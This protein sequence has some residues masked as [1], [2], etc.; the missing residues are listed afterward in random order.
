M[1][2]YIKYFVLFILLIFIGAV[3]INLYHDYRL[4]D[5]FQKGNTTEEQQKQDQNNKQEDEEQSVQINSEVSSEQ[6][7]VDQ[8]ETNTES[9]DSDSSDNVSNSVQNSS[10]KN[11]EAIEQS[12]NLD[13]YQVDSNSDTNQDEYI[14]IE[15]DSNLFRSREVPS[16]SN[17]SVVVQEESSVFS[18][19]RGTNNSSN[20]SISKDDSSIEIDITDKNPA[21]SEKKDVSD[22][23]NQDQSGLPVEVPQVKD[24][25]IEGATGYSAL[26]SKLYLKKSP[27]DQSESIIVLKQGEPFLIISSA[28]SGNW[29]KV[30]YN[31]KIG[32]VNTDYCMIN[33]PDYIPSIEYYITNAT[34]SIYQSSGVK[35]S[36]TGKKLYTASMVYNPR[37]GRDEYIVPVIYSFAQKI[38]LAQ[39]EANKN[40]YSLKIY[41][42]YRPKSVADQVKD[43]LLELYNR[44]Q[45]VRNGINYSYDKNGKKYTWGQGWFIAQNLS[46]H[47]LAA[48]IDVTLITK[49][50][51]QELSM[52]SVIHELST[53]AIKYTMPISGQTTVRSDLYA[54][55]MTAGAKELD[56][57]M[58]G[59]GLTS[60]A[61]EWWHFQ[62]NMA[63]N[64]I[65][66]Y[67]SKGIDV[68]PTKI[69]SE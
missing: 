37:L 12:E 34:S 41:D 40:G 29:W 65:K 6:V 30:N 57:I 32:Y 62:D 33:L 21:T 54:S 7:T 9:F 10:S 56:R 20:S 14:T 17:N 36:V 46:A 38:L 69:V 50:T 28:S 55:S 3:S 58:M 61:S 39:Q 13:Y 31:G 64:R 44:N 25:T 27:D 22:N 26:N 45:T 19:Q 11:V 52:P 42:A 53:K 59:V 18:I 68:Q 23:V 63:Y 24:G 4:D 49:D 2:G 48:A 67:E 5:Q 16:G 60:L 1:K 66:V 8:A 51:K 47:S 43:S 15:V 35:M